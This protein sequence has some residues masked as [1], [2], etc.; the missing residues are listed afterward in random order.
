MVQMSQP[1]ASNAIPVHIQRDARLAEVWKRSGHILSAAHFE[2]KYQRTLL[3]PLEWPKLRKQVALLKALID[4]EPG[5]IPPRLAEKSEIKYY[6]CREILDS[7]EWIEWHSQR[8]RGSNAYHFFPT[9]N[10]TGQKLVPEEIRIEYLVAELERH[11]FEF[12]VSR[13]SGAYLSAQWPGRQPAGCEYFFEAY[14]AEIAK[15]VL[16]RDSGRPAWWE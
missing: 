15:Y 10:E 5:I 1:S 6:R 3:L 13:G 7:R 4:I 8:I 2:E 9:E 11:G 16:K 12:Q 14:R